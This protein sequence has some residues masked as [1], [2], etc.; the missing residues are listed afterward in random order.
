MIDYE[1][2]RQL[3]E[4]HRPK[5]IVA[6][7]SAY[8]RIIDFARLRE[9]ADGVGAL[10]MADIAHIA[11]LIAAGLHPTSIGYAHFTT[12]TTHKTLRGPR[13]GLIMTT[14]EYAKAIDKAIF[15]GIQG[16]HPD[17][18][19][20]PESSRRAGAQPCRRPCWPASRCGVE[21]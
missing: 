5:M 16:G 20:W 2:V 15:P 14:E 9:I 21:R 1:E 4:T 17:R 8:P 19:A 3:A 10:L 6:G 11:G 13:G 12:T 7:A 18:G